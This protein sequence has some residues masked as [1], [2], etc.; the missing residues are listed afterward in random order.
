MLTFPGCSHDV[1]AD[2]GGPGLRVVL[3]ARSAGEWWQQLINGADHRLAELLSAAPP[4]MLGPLTAGWARR[5]EFER[6]VTKFAARLGVARPAAELTVTEPDA[7]ILAVH[8]AALLAVLDHSAPAR[9]APVPGRR[10][11]QPRPAV[12]TRKGG[13]GRPPTCLRDCCGMKPRTGRKPPTTRGLSLDPSAQRRAVAAA[14]LIGADSEGRAAALVARLPGLADPAE[15]RGEVARWL[16]EL[17][18]VGPTAEGEAAEWLG[19]L[20]PDLV[21]EQLV[22][23]VL[24][25]I[26]RDCRL[27]CWLGSTSSAPPGR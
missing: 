11:R 2:P 18:P 8:A 3:L 1:A 16:H 4:V 13:G 5:E 23:D 24:A 21:A 15:R 12:C 25:A 6:A 20:R 7:V 9:R 19:S 10:Q 14:C 27:A 22:A 17:Y 26:A